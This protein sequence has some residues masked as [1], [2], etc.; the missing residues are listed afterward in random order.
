ML[1]TVQLFSRVPRHL[2]RILLCLAALTVITAVR[3]APL[4]AQ[5]IL[6]RIREKA[7]AKLNTLEDSLSNQ[8]VDEATGAVQCLITN[9]ECMKNAADSAKPVKV[10]DKNGNA[11]T[12]ADSAKAIST[13][14]G[15]RT[16]PAAAMTTPAAPTTPATTTATPV[17]GEGVFV[18]YDF[19]PGERVLFAEDFTRDKPGDFPRRLQLRSGNFEVASWQA[20]QFLR[21]N[22]AGDIAIPLPEV[23]PQRFTF[24]ADYSGGAGWDLKI[25]FADPGSGDLTSATFSP[26][27]GGL[28][29]AGVSSSSNLPDGASRPLTHIAVMADGN[30]VKTYVNGVR[31]TNVPNANL[32]RSKA[33]IVAFIADAANPAYMT[34]IR[35]AAGGK[36]LYDA[37]M[38]DGRVATH[39]ILFATGSDAIQGESKPTL[40]QIGQMLQQH[41]DLKLTIEG[42]TDNVGSATSN[43]TLSEKRAAAVR[44]YLIANYQ[45]DGSRLASK[46]FGATKPAA[47]NDTPEGRQQN[48]RVELVK[49]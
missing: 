17:P 25:S 43:Q 28:L 21:T 6:D 48:R 16:T 34:N 33:I 44:Q 23:L 22:E 41:P 29:G 24:E 42:H 39:G 46:G 12:S 32:G 2:T 40:E 11:V 1:R 37:I 15:A 9:L 13:A 31:V 7:K 3:P 19:I 8:I 27:S 26:G 47:S 20:Q 18:N 4:H 45:V 49:M 35:V 36:Q 14:T 30:Y 5:S 10:V 38:A